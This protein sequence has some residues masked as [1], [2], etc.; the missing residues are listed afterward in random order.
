MVE[1]LPF[2]DRKNA[3]FPDKTNC[4]RTTKANFILALGA[5]L[6]SIPLAAI[7]AVSSAENVG[8][9]KLLSCEGELIF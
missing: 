8:K 7:Q 2:A 3:H 5:I 6:W 1:Y 9:I 4:S